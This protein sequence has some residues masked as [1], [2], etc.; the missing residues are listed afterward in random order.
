MTVLYGLA[1]FGAGM[2]VGSIVLTSLLLD[3]KNKCATLKLKSG[4]VVLCPI[5]RHSRMVNVC[6]DLYAIVADQALDDEQIDNLKASIA[7]DLKALFTPSET[8]EGRTQPT[9]AP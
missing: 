1:L 5:D 7:G 4:H 3:M 6:N 2:V 9:T 8:Q